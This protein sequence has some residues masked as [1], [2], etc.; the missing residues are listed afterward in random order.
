MLNLV[1][2]LHVALLTPSLWPVAR[3]RFTEN[4]GVSELP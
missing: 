4:V 1:V 2:S 3:T